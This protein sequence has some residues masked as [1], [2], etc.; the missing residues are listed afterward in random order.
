LLSLRHYWDGGADPRRFANGITSAP[1]RRGFLGR[2]NRADDRRL[3]CM[4]GVR[5]VRVMTSGG[6]SLRRLAAQR[7]E[8]RAAFSSEK[9]K[10]ARQIDA[11]CRDIGFL[12]ITGHGVSSD[13]IERTQEVSRAFFDLP[14]AMKR[15]SAAAGSRDR[16]GWAGA[17]PDAHGHA[18]QTHQGIGFVTRGR[19]LPS[20]PAQGNSC[21]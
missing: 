6:T 11:A 20:I 2:T 12:V 9:L 21:L 10:I 5:R 19:G 8:D 7:G 1:F 14:E 16:L 13:L 4:V 17:A 18:R 15:R 3:C